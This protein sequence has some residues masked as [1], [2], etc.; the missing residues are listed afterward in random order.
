VISIMPSSYRE[1]FQSLFLLAP[2]NQNGIYQESSFR[3]RSSE[4][5][6]GLAMF[7]EHPLL[8]VGAGNY[9]NNYQKYTHLV[10]LELRSGERDPHSLYVQI[11]AETGI[12]G[13]VAFA[14]FSI[15]LLINLHRA[16]RSIEHLSIYQSWGPWVSAIQLTIVGY[17]LISIFLHGAYLRYFWIF[18]ALAMSAIQ[19]SDAMLM[20]S[21]R[22][23]SQGTSV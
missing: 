22:S 8:G 20:K 16:R 6:T 10:G 21:E 2:T 14:G 1:R 23:L 18:V 4:M 9:P 3:G 13:A 11:L 15:L 17:L 7:T 19:L 12:V 5:L